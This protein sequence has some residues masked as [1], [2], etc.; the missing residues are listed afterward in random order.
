MGQVSQ[1]CRFVLLLCLIVLLFGSNRL[2]LADQN[3]PSL[4]G[5]FEE[6]QQART[7]DETRQI[8]AQ[9]WA[10][11]LEPPDAN[12]DA[13]LSQVTYAMS[14][15]QYQLALRLCDQLVDSQPEFAEGWNKRATVQYL[16]GNHAYSVADIKQTLLLEPRHFG[17]LSGLGLI[18]MA[19]GNYAAAVDVFEAVLEISP[20][21][22]N[23]QGSV[24]QAKALMGDDI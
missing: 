8:E 6:L 21:S 17:A 23:A 22:D 16:L 2:S 14:V 3:H 7:N 24:A 19:A 18:F 10:A 4:T 9:I 1:Q 13:L 20:A 5:L 12:S 11:W 15:G